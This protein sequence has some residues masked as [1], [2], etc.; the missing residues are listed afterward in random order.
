MKGYKGLLFA[1][2]SPLVTSIATILIGGAVKLI[3]PWIVLSISPLIGS[4]I[5]FFIAWFKGQRFRLQEL[6]DNKNDIFS[7]IFTRQIVGWA[8]F[9]L[10]LTFTDV[11]KAIF[12][13]KVEPYFVLLFH[14]IVYKEKVK[15]KHLILLAVHIFGAILLSTGGKFIGFGRSQFGDLFVIVSMACAAL[16]YIPAAKLS[17]VMGAIKINTIMLFTAGLVFL[18]FTLFF[19][20]Q[21][22]GWISIRGWIYLIGYSV[23]FS[24]IGLTLWF[25]SLKTVKSWIV[26]SLRALGPLI[27]VPFAY[28][29]LGETLTLTQLLGGLI[30]LATSF[31]IAR[32]HLS[33]VRKGE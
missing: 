5:L 12:F 17:R 2:I 30:V 33:I 18:P 31:L 24:C 32:E 26:S 6:R 13:T 29:L 22:A 25:A 1:I 16:S 19:S 21:V 11:I 10:G 3:N 14:W 27:G 4:V 8:I 28:F 15:R 20:T 9:V 23:L 7:L